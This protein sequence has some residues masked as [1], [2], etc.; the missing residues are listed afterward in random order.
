M[1]VQRC[2]GAPIMPDGIT[3]RGS[4]T[5]L[6]GAH[7]DARRVRYRHRLGG[8]FPPSSQIVSPE[9]SRLAETRIARPRRHIGQFLE[10]SG[11]LRVKRRSGVLGVEMKTLTVCK[12]SSFQFR[13]GPL[14]VVTSR[15]RPLPRREWERFLSGKSD[16]FTFIGVWGEILRETPQASQ[17]ACINICNHE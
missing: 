16:T 6:V 1:A 15:R 4:I 5:F 3:S 11:V 13:M 8:V 14:D 9:L 10:S 2:S 7:P 17:L 12:W